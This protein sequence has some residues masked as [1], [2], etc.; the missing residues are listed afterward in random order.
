MDLWREREGRREGGT[1][2][3]DW[4]GLIDGVKRQDGWGRRKIRTMH[5]RGERQRFARRDWGMESRGLNMQKLRW[6]G[7]TPPDLCWGSK[8]DGGN[9]TGL[10]LDEC[11]LLFAKANTLY[12]NTRRCLSLCLCRCL[13]C[14][15]MSVGKHKKKR[16]KLALWRLIPTSKFISVIPNNP[17]VVL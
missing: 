12:P 5:E 1:L 7:I 3:A 10:Q 9:E 11:T 6:N 13:R 16:K 2:R 8:P 15:C 14:P 17:V 4:E